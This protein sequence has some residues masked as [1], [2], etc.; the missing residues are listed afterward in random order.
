MGAPRARAHIAPGHKA[1]S[2]HRPGVYFL[3]AL[4][5]GSWPVLASA[6]APAAALPAPAG[7]AQAVEVM[8]LKP[9]FYMLSVDGMHLGLE[10]GE[11]GAILVD[12]GPAGAASAVVRQIKRLSDQPLR[13]IID[14][15]ADPDLIGG[16]A[17]LSAAGQS[18]MIG[19]AVLTRYANDP[20][21]IPAEHILDV[22]A[23]IIARQSVTEQML[24]ASGTAPSPLQ[25]PSEVF[26]R[27]QYVFRLNGQIVR[28]VRM[29][30]AHT[31]ADSVVRFDG[32]DVVVTGAIFDVTHFPVIDLQHGG[33][34]QG[35]IDALN[36]LIGTLVVASGPI[37]TDSDG[38]LVVP[39]RGHVCNQPDLVSYRD[40]LASIRDGVARL[41]DKGDRLAA[42]EAANPAM[43]YETRYGSGTDAWTT[44]DFIA[45][46]YASLM[47]Q[48][49]PP[50]RGGGQ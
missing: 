33:S 47:A 35:E 42:V 40:M 46:V 25:L 11:D 27:P 28:V 23:P 18:L 31:S 29:P 41:I 20:N 12:T 50:Q 16:N 2:A 43:G 3:F 32:S 36:Q 14:T 6:A 24:S 30:N 15:S 37:V 7:S 26:T 39:L 22:R 38:T 8:Q 34:I 45:A 4:L 17:I 19:F 5:T 49:H 10:T 1:G 44:H 48:R 21:A 9:D 13:F